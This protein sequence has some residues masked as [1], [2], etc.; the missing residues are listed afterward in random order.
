MR[1][2][3]FGT[4]LDQ[5]A[6][7]APTPGGGAVASIV[8]A[9]G[10]ALAQMAMRYSIRRKTPDDRREAIEEKISELDAIVR[11]LLDA[12][13]EDERA[14][15]ELNRLQRLDADDPVRRSGWSSAVEAA[16]AAPRSVV[17]ESAALVKSLREFATECNRWLLSDLAIAAVLAEAAARSAAWNVEINLP[18]LDDETKRAEC[19][20][21]LKSDLD[22]VHRYAEFVEDYCRGGQ[23]GVE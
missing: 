16:I 2:Q 6:A 11:R 21:R 10:G 8:G 14:Y 23:T 5:I 13:A 19:A 7:R 3:P 4:L 17:G 15:G 22:D 12:A 18:L 20:R 1:D 9:L